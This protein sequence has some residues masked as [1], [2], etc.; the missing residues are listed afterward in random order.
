MSTIFDAKAE[1]RKLQTLNFAETNAVVVQA[2]KEVAAFLL[3]KNFD[4]NRSLYRYRVA[5]YQQMM[6]DGEWVIGDPIKFSSDGKLIDG[7]HRLSAVPDGVVVP[8]VIL[9]GQPKK[10]AETYDQGMRRNALHIASIRGV[11]GLSNSHISI[12]RMM[13]YFRYS[14]S[15][16]LSAAASPKKLVDIFEAHPSLKSAID[17]SL[18]Y[19]NRNFGFSF[20]P[21]NAA[22][23]RAKLS[24]YPLSDQDLDFFLH[25]LQGGGR[26][27]YEEGSERSDM[28]PILLRNIYLK[29]RQEPGR[30]GSSW[31]RSF[32][33][34]TQSA[35]VA[36]SEG[37]KQKMLK[38][39]T[40]NV[41]PVP[42][43]DYMNL[44]TLKFDPSI[45]N[46]DS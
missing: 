5:N 35:L 6:L 44:K 27:D 2:D 13:F 36:F 40:K 41:F 3:G 45:K 10:A 8:F 16:D 31:R 24:D 26:S 28:A 7:Q 30:S 34:R 4:A 19:K 22:I 18:R 39:V 42:F 37:K 29:E 14:D 32:F 46:R 25:I 12:L 33:L 17:F 1:I 11:E 20:A 9:T 43:L 23:A 21:I 38:K 15:H